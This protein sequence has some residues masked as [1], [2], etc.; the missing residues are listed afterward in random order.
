M[1]QILKQGQAQLML[2]ASI[3]II[4]TSLLRDLMDKINDVNVTFQWKQET[5]N[6]T[7]TLLE[8]PMYTCDLES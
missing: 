3:V 2:R 4:L 7:K 6:E 1:G 5:D 8:K